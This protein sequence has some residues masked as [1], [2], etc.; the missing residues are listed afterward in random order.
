MLSTRYPAAIL[1]LTFAA[2]LSGCAPAAEP[3]PTPTPAF[4]SEEEAF[5]AA[6]EVY[7]AY[8]EAVNA[9]RRGDEEADP[10]GFLIGFA[11]EGDTDARR[12]LASEGIVISGDGEITEFTPLQ[13]EFEAGVVSVQVLVCLDV[14]GT[15]VLDENGVDVTPSNRQS[16][17]PLLVTLDESDHQLMVSESTADGGQTC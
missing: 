17:V 3:S 11:L 2:A 7:R 5:A 4:A 9:E 12:V 14:S 10:R 6:E 8:N 1:A 15:A 13:A 16:K